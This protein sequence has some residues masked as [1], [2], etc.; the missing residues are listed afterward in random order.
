GLCD[1]LSNAKDAEIKTFLV[2]RLQEVGHDDAV[3]TLAPLLA[4]ETVGLHAAAALERVG[5]PA[6]V[7]ALRKAFPTSAGARRVAIIKS[8]GMLRATDSV[9]DIR[10]AATDDDKTLRM[11]AIW[12]LANLGDDGTRDLLA[13]ATAN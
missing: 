12:A 13:K 10:P 6:A 3:P 1:A 7:A 11:T 5:T 9:A 2:N 8:L 4:D